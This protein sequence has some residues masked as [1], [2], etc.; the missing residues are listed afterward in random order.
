M[1]NYSVC[2]YAACMTYGCSKNKLCSPC[3]FVIKLDFL[4]DTDVVPVG[5]DNQ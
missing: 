1:L 4:H 3:V 2:K 5:K